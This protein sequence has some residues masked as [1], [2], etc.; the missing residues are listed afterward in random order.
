MNVHYLVADTETTGQSDEDRIVEIAWIEIDEN[1][2]ELSRVYS[3]IDPERSIS[4]SASGVH[5]IT[6][7]M[8]QDEPTID[9]FFNVSLQPPLD[10]P[11]VLIAHKADFDKRMMQAP[12]KRAGIEIASTLCT[13]RLARRYL[14]DAENHKLTTLAYQYGLDKGTAHNALGDVIMA[15]SLLRFIA[16]LAEKSLHQ[17]ME[18]AAQP[19]II[20]KMPFGKHRDEPITAMPR[21]YAQWAVGWAGKPPGLP[22]IDPDLK[23]TLK[24]RAS[25]EL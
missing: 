4:A 12:L 22:D 9:E 16:G 2:N 25:G 17:L 3:R 14:K 21:S 11:I 13:L 20:D 19:F 24:L 23:H 1:L 6:I 15:T 8:L 18:E 5:G 7:D 10:R